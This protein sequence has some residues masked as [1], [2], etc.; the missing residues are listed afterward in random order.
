MQALLG[1]F[2]R[3]E[4]Q[5]GIS[6]CAEIGLNLSL[7]GAGSHFF[8]LVSGV[9]VKRQHS[10]IPIESMLPAAVS[11]SQSSFPLFGWSSCAGNCSGSNGPSS[12]AFRAGALSAPA[13][14]KMIWAALQAAGAVR[15]MR[16]AYNLPT[17]FLTAMRLSTC[18]AFVPG[19]S[20]R[21]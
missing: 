11:T 3:L 4:S 7:D 17:Q 9:T 18:N 2:R 16:S 5:Q 19:K 6:L 10:R 1:D 21:G 12:T 8:L 13:T 14:R 20:E 15:V